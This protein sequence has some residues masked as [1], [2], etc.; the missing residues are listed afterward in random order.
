MERVPLPMELELGNSH[1]SQVSRTRG[2]R[3]QDWPERPQGE[4]S[5]DA[6]AWWGHR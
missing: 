1:I 4:G 3:G 5:W 2:R 6:L